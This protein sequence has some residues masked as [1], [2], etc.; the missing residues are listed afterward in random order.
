MCTICRHP[1]RLVIERDLLA[2]PS[3]GTVAAHHNLPYHEAVKH[4]A[5]LE[6]R[7]E[8]ARRQVEQLLLSES[9]S[10]LHLLLEKTLKVVAAAEEKGDLKLMMQAIREAGRLTQMLHALPVDLAAPAL[11]LAA[12]D[13]DW[14]RAASPLPTQAWVQDSVRQA[15]R[16]SLQNPCEGSHFEP[17][18]SPPQASPPARPVAAVRRGR[19]AP[20]P[21]TAVIPWPSTPGDAVGSG[22]AM[23]DGPG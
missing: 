22:A 6:A 3:V 4:K 1:S 2:C 17:D 10:R 14:P 15:I 5:R 8:E 11:F 12:T 13:K 21:S 23:P 7:V 9:L 18:L 20:R 19:S 16:Q